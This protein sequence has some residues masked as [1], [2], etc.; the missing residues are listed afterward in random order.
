M[1]SDIICNKLECIR[2]LLKTVKRYV[3]ALTTL[4]LG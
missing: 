1:M 3:D 2:E 4:M